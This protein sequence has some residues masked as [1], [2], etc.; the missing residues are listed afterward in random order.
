MLPKPTLAKR[1]SAHEN[2]VL[3]LLLVFVIGAWGG[4]YVVAK[5]A[6]AKNGPWVFNALRYAVAA[7]FLAAWFC[8]QK[9][10]RYLLPV[11]GEFGWTVLIGLLQISV[12][13]S[14]TNWALTHIDANRTILITYSMPIWAL[15]FGLLLSRDLVNLQSVIGVAL[16]FG[17][18]ALFCA[19]WSMDW[20]S[21]DSLAGS[22]AALLGS[23]SWALG[24]V[25]Y[26]RFAWTSSLGQQIFLQVLTAAVTAVL[27]AAAFEE[28]PLLLDA[29]YVGIIL[30]NALVPTILAFW[31]WAKIL[32]LIPAATAGQFVLLSPV[33][34]ILLGSL[35][36]GE[37]VTP[38]LIVSATLILGGALLAY[39]KR[40]EIT[41]RVPN[42][43]P[44]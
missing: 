25:L 34:G 32:T 28:R 30:Y 31:F 19:P 20:T 29:R 1:T 33:F 40:A 3:S 17:G 7:V 18:L 36:L 44:S 13:T 39:M 4:N 22:G 16:G 9:G 27:C 15:F 26:R 43:T 37:T 24:A 6:V 2:I 41:T 12:T 35:V 38:T 14:S 10:W 8:Y 5:V 42:E 21:Y 11:R 23:V